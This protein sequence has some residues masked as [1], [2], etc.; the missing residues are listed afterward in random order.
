MSPLVFIIVLNWNGKHHLQ[1]CLDSLSSLDYPNYRILLV[2]NN[3]KD[4]SLSLATDKYPHVESIQNSDNLGFAEGN[5]VGIRYALS[6]RADYVVLLNNDTRVEPDFLQHLIQ[7]GEAKNKT[8]V[9][10]G[11]ILMFS[12]PLIVNSTG[13][14]LNLFAYGWDRDFGENRI[15]I[16]NEGGEVLAVSGCLMAIKREV[17]EEVGLLDPKFFAYFEDVDFCLRVWSRSDFTVEYV[18][19]AVVYHKFSASSGDTSLFKRRLMMR[20]QY[21]VFFKHFPPA[22]IMKIFPRLSL[23]RLHMLL[24]C[25]LRSDLLFFFRESIV[26][27]KY[28]MA[29]PFILCRRILESRSGLDS[30]RFWE[31]VIPEMVV[32]SIKAYTP[33][34]ERIFLSK[35]EVANKEIPTRIVMGLNDEIL[36][37]GWSQLIHEFPRIRRIEK[38]AVC[39]LRNE[40]KFEF[41][42]IHGLWDTLTDSLGLQVE[43]E[44]ERACQTN[45]VHG[46]HTYLIPFENCFAARPMEVRIRIISFKPENIET[47]GLGVNEVGLLPLGSPLLRLVGY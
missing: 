2:D 45:V 33:G 36:G 43:I 14:N 28:W 32:P 17:L 18:P 22:Q 39:Y 16:G 6:K 30:S 31:K 15:A 3:S 26:L 19:H 42:Q 37:S 29:L 46:W 13:V 21:R 11:T 12:N 1:D 34:Y 41:L 24:H 8:G 4:G 47:R 20:N 35:V 27:L 38:E 5:N 40:R 23:H 7:R 9:L 44:G 25:L 10:G